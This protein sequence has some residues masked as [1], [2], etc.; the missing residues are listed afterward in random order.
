MQFVLLLQF[1]QANSRILNIFYISFIK[2]TTEEFAVRF[3]MFHYF[4]VYEI[5]I[6]SYFLREKANKYF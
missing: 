2:Y 3:Q 5:L 6:V 4:Q 1:S